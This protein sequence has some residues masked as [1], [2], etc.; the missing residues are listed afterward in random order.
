MGNKSSQ[1]DSS[2]G[3]SRLIEDYL[4]DGVYAVFDPSTGLIWLDTRGQSGFTT[5]PQGRLAVAI[6]PATL[7]KLNRFAAR[8]GAIDLKG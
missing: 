1:S 4:D 6:E 8:C 3:S 5:G 2:C 7:N